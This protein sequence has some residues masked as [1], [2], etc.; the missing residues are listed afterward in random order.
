[1][2]KI[3]SEFDIEKYPL[4]K[5]KQKRLEYKEGIKRKLFNMISGISI[6][7]TN[8]FFLA[9]RIKNIVYPE[10][11]NTI[12][13][14]YAEWPAEIYA[15]ILAT[16]TT[17]TLITL[18][19]IIILP[20]IYLLFALLTIGFGLYL[21]Q[22]SKLNSSGIEGELFDI[23]SLW[24]VVSS[25]GIPIKDQVKTIYDI[26]RVYKQVNIKYKKLFPEYKLYNMFFEMYYD[27][28]KRNFQKPR[29]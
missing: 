28:E 11:H 19:L 22:Y 16:L 13:N 2:K 5:L 12:V 24:Y 27:M 18:P 21:N 23:I 14:T 9:K 26:L 25:S 29:N 20:Q 3:G 7:F 8:K 17:F 10:L 6:R 4:L 15:S 1:M